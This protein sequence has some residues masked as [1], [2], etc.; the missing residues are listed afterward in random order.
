MTQLLDSFGIYTATINIWADNQS[1]LKM[2]KN[3]I[4]STRIKHIDVV[5][6]FDRERVAK[7]DVKF[8]YI[9]TKAMLA[10]MLTKAVPANTLAICCEGIGMG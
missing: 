2:L 6:H 8:S 5:Y 4:A 10:D 7:G 9:S 3:P 1:A